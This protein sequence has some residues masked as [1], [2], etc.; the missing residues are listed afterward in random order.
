[1]LASNEDIILT[2]VLSTLMILLFAVVV[3][4]AIVK[5]RSKQKEFLQRENTI[6]T[7]LVKI[8]LEAKEQTL[9][10]IAERIHVDIQQTLSLAKLNLSKVL[11]S[12]D[13]V[14]IYKI[15]QSKELITQTI[16]EI[17]S[18]SKEFDPKY[19]TGH[20]LEENIARQLERVEKRTNLKTVFNTSEKE[21]SLNNEKQIFI[22][23]II[24]EAINNILAHAEATQIKINLKNNIGNFMLTIEDNGKGFDPRS[25]YDSKNNHSNGMGLT[26]MRSRTQLMNGIFTIE[27]CENRGIKIMLKIPNHD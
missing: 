11:M 16:Q 17:K 9:E 4:I 13:K 7:E 1:M 8:L 25:L 6:K 19:I 24:Q 22:Y 21:I 2:I 5:Y 20:T 12:S 26:N 10:G 23:R 14:D 18:L 3:V 27:N 15:K